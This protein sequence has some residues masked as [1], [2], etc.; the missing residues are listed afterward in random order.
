VKTLKS[1]KK[2]TTKYIFQ[3]LTLKGLLSALK[4]WSNMISSLTVLLCVKS[5]EPCN[6]PNIL[7]NNM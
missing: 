4:Q 7:S 6:D 2:L 5:L 1:L 3:Q